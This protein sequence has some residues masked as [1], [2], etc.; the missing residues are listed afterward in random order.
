MGIGSSTLLGTRSSAMCRSP[1]VT[2]V[3][4][5]SFLA[6]PRRGARYV[7]AGRDTHPHP[8]LPYEHTGQRTVTREP[9]HTRHCRRVRLECVQ[10][11]EWG[12][13]GCQDVHGVGSFGRCVGESV[14]AER[15]GGCPADGEMPQPSRLR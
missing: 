3:I 2:V 10:S 11:S 9:H 4:Y 7:H 5:G 6:D 15:G 12:E 1:E 14:R 8:A 13:A